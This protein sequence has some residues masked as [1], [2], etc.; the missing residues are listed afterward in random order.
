MERRGKR[1]HETDNRCT[2][3]KKETEEDKRS[4]GRT[5]FN[6]NRASDACVCPPG[7]VCVCVCVCKSEIDS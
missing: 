2:K 4:D 7:R 5:L 1:A 6:Y 3:T